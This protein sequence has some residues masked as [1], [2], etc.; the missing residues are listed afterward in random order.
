MLLGEEVREP[1]GVG[2]PGGGRLVGFLTEQSLQNRVQA[3]E[4][5][6]RGVNLGRRTRAHT[7]R[8]GIGG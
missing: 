2:S 8:G 3:A 4:G 5:G 6:L 7:Q 1:A